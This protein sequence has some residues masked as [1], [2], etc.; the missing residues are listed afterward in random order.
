[1]FGFAI[2]III[3]TWWLTVFILVSRKTHML[4]QESDNIP[5]H[6]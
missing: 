1:M 4:K 3:P 2:L 6:I 5:V